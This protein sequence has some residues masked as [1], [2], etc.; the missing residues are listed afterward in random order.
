MTKSIYE[1]VR[2][3]MDANGAD[4]ILNEEVACRCRGG[5]IMMCGAVEPGCAPAQSFD[6]AG[7]DDGWS[8]RA[9][10]IRFM[11]LVAPNAA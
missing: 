1:I 10:A 5:N 4:A 6:D 2:E 8:A 3:A 11:P 9:V 7:Q